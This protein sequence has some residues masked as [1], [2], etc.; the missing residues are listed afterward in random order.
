MFKI[1]KL[2]KL[3]LLL[4]LILTCNLASSQIKS[5]YDTSKHYIHFSPSKFYNAYD[6]KTS[7]ALYIRSGDTVNTESLDALGFDKDSIKKG[8]RGNPLTGP[9]FIEG[10]S[11]GDVV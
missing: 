11:V 6:P 5:L 1:D 10:A 7:P 2:M 8:E 9:F 3:I 4:L